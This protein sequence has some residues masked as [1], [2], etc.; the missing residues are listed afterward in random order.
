MRPSWRGVVVIAATVLVAAMAS[1]A[2]GFAASG[3]NITATEGVSFSGRVANID[4]CSFTNATISWGDGTSSAGQLDNSGSTHGVTG[5]HTYGEEGSYN[6]SVT[7][8]TDCKTNAMV[9]FMATVADAPLTATGIDISP[10]EGVSFTG[11]VSH[12]TDADPQGM[13]GDYSAQIDWG[14][15][16]HSTG[17]VAAASSGGFD[18]TGTHTY[19]SAGHVPVTVTITDVG[20]SSTASSSTATIGSAA[21]CFHVGTGQEL[22]DALNSG[23][24]CIYVNNDARIDLGQIQPMEPDCPPPPPNYIAMGP[25]PQ[26]RCSVLR[27]P[28][29]VTLESGRSAT[30]QGGLLYLTRQLP[31]THMLDLGSN[32][33]ITG[34]R[35]EGYD[36]H[37]TSDPLATRHPERTSAIQIG[38]VYYV[39]SGA[40]IPV[41][42]D[43]ILIDN[44]DIGGWP[45]AAIGVASNGTTIGTAEQVRITNNF[46]HDNVS[47]EGGGYGV[48]IGADY[49][50][51]AAHAYIDRN[52]FDDNR[53]DISDDGQPT[54]GYFAD[55]NFTLYSGPTCDGNYNQH[56]D[57]HGTGSDHYGGDAGDYTEIMQNT[58]RGAQ[59]Y[60]GT[61][62]FH[63]STRPAFELRGTP[64]DKAI[65]AEN[66]LTHSNESEALKVEGP[67]GGAAGLESR[68][69]LF[70][71][72]NQ[73]N[74]DTSLQLAV[75]DF[76]ADHHDDVFQ[77]T[78]AGWWYSPWGRSQ[79][80][81]LR[82]DTHRSP[83]LALGDFNGD[84]KTDVF[85]QEGDR[86]LVSYGGTGP[87]TPL[88]AGSN[89]PMSQYRFGDFNGD[90]K[91]DIFRTNGNQ[92][93][94]SSGGA[95]QWIPLQTSSKKIGELR[96]CD[97]NGDGKTD[98][99][100][101]A[102]HQWSVS[103]GGSTSWR[104]LNAELSSNLGELVFADFNGDGRCD[105]ARSHDGEWQVSWGGRTPWRLLRA[106][107]TQE[108]SAELVGHFTGSRR[109]DVL[110]FNYRSGFRLL[111]RLRWLISVGARTGFGTWSWGDMS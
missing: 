101:L 17:I 24:K 105:I 85:T 48:V 87:L 20:G 3:V 50:Y 4:S 25:P 52:V 56:F 70:V 53:H 86:W 94:Y 71:Y 16:T 13:V 88:P 63:R 12:F 109:A 89:I 75:G 79:W 44:N 43:H 61:L 93:Y 73:Y 2:M 77:A 55:R 74:V 10:T 92:W 26:Q 99:F 22:V 107:A 102:N 111:A 80:R 30:S 108:L 41:L 27:I 95:T 37:D 84:G 34:L 8:T 78:G 104:R 49:G 67:A 76:D 36:P 5:T 31:Q 98:V 29:G 32:T 60:G 33:R 6:G 11:V 66:A 15:N 91:T 68:Q 58:F 18:V 64:V 51:G 1:P 40:D 97:F 59:T 54:T 106:H 90:R 39:G 65:F 82:A 14:D 83:Q 57:M 42:R 72:G 110:D 35:I 23:Y 100:S 9:P 62:G 28:D 19:G 21:G 38:G 46:I 96:F 47:C 45:A 81:F 103:Y 69:E 7:Y